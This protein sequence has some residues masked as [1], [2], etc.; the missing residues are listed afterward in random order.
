ML[1]DSP[2]ALEWCSFGCEALSTR[3]SAWQ[4]SETKHESNAVLAM[5]MVTMG[6]VL[7]GFAA[8]SFT[9]AAELVR[10]GNTWKMGEKIPAKL[11][12]YHTSYDGSC[13]PNPRGTD[14]LFG[15]ISNYALLWE[16]ALLPEVDSRVFSNSVNR[17]L[18]ITGPTRFFSDLATMLKERPQLEKQERIATL[19]RQSRV[20]QIVVDSLYISSADMPPEAGRK[21]LDEISLELRQGKP[22]HDVYWQFM[23]RHEYPY[24]EKLS[25]GTVIKGNRTRIGNLGDFFLPENGNTLFSYREEWF[26]KK[27]RKQLFAANAGEILILF[28]KENLSPFPELSAKQ[29]GERYVLY[30]VREV[31]FG[32]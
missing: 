18:I 26:P 3:L 20:R 19:K 22:W 14:M 30:Q 16:I 11:L 17:A 4:R 15:A 25:D 24:E 28:D 23:E 32:K 7:D 29:T 1:L 6:T 9:E 10:A 5:C 21:I 2:N 31:Y 12:K 27:H 8:D 13:F